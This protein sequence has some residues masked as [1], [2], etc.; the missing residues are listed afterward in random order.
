MTSRADRPSKS[1]SQNPAT[2]LK[3]APNRPNAQI[4]AHPLKPRPGLFYTL[5]IIFILWIA[6]LLTMY[7]TT[8]Y[9][10]TDVHVQGSTSR[11][12]QEEQ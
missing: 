11:T 6:G 12:E 1:T 2:E 3:T 5:L 9:H 8:V 10:K 4:V 7:F